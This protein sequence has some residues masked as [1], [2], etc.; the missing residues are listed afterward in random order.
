MLVRGKVCAVIM[1]KFYS[2]SVGLVYGTFITKRKAGFSFKNVK[3]NSTGNKK[4]RVNR[5]F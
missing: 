1:N 5:S 4:E 2:T 3:E